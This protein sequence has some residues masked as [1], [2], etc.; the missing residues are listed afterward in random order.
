MLEIINNAAQIIWDY[1]RLNHKVKEADLIIGLGGHDRGVAK[2]ASEL[3]ISKFAPLLLFTGKEGFDKDLANLNG[4]SEASVFKEIAIGLGV[5]EE[6]II[7]EEESINTGQNALYS[8][9]TLERLG[10]NPE[11]V[12]LVTK[13]YGERRVYATF[14]AQW[15]GIQP[16]F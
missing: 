11:M 9:N 5:S 1:N 6:N 14:L 3:Y 2:I 7:I 4:K 8:H 12:I 13:P 16:N 15:P 10:L